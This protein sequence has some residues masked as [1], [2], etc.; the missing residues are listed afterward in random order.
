MW[1]LSYLTRVLIQY[2]L[3]LWFYVHGCL[4]KLTRN[5][6]KNLIVIDGTHIEYD[7]DIII[8]LSKGLTK[9]ELISIIESQKE[10][11]DMKICLYYDYDGKESLYYISGNREI[12]NCVSDGIIKTACELPI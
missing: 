1:F 12:R 2:L 7:G 9:S 11:F 4:W 8:C 10:K 5:K 6:N 3:Y